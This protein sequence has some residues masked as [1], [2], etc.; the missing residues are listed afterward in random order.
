MAS[1]LGWG[2]AL[3]SSTIVAA[4]AGA[5]CSAA[6]ASGGTGGDGQGGSS[7]NSG[8]SATG[9]GAGSNTG[10]FTSGT[11]TSSSGTG[12]GKPDCDPSC[13]AVGGTCNAGVCTI[14]DNGGNVD[15]GTRGKLDVGGNGDGSFAWLYPY[16]KTVFP[17]GLI[18][19]Q[20]QFAGAPPDAL[21]VHATAPGLDY[22]GYF[23]ASNPARVRISDP[24]WKA[25]TLAVHAKDN[26]HVEVTKI[27]GGQA[28]GPIKEDW[29]IA[30]G[31]LRGTIYYET[32][33]SQILGGAASVGIMKISPGALQ[34]TII[35]SG[36]GNVCHTASAD[37]STLVAAT[38]LSFGSASYDLKNNAATIKAQSDY[39]FTYGGI[40]PD[41]SFVVSASNYRT[42]IPFGTSKLYDTKTGLSIPTPSWEN[43]VKN[44]GTPAFSPDGKW[45]AFN[46]EDNGGGHTL[47]TMS[48][49]KVSNNFAGLTDVA[50]DPQYTL[51][52]PAFTPD[53]KQLVFHA[54]SNAE[55][56]TD[57]G[58]QGD[59]YGTDLAT[60]TK[61]RLD[62]LDGYAN[63]KSY[64]PAN[65][66]LLNFAPTVLPEAVGGYFWVVFTSHRSYGNTLPSQ[67]NGDQ[68]GKLWVAALDINGVAG[69]DGSHPAFYLD[70]QEDSADNLRGFWVLPPCKADGADCMSGDECCGGYCRQEDGGPMICTPIQGGCSQEYDKC[71]TAADCCDA[72]DECI[73]GHCAQPPPK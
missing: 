39:S 68:N 64:L 62:A 37:G 48:Y 55:F 38:F 45:I 22:K 43:A 47:A 1:R 2:I 13:Q 44:P 24:M 27:S 19:P 56:E 52:W 20:L 60:K 8:P 72:T 35:K 18:P 25:L 57:S 59:L 40:Y 61:V 71:S 6:G 5:N 50:N 66:P 58:A 46:H 29:T 26:L 36:C 33:G 14:V 63:G 4:I 23:A 16:D 65:D 53:S 28:A 15:P 32:Y 42:W 34:P 30:Q 12:G 17:R 31:S 73:N 51:G 9:T 70:G 41:G 49:D 3:V 7:S 69:Q 11:S 21:E 10:G 54:G 67:D